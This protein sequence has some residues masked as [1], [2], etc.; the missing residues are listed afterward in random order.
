MEQGDI[1]KA[2]CNRCSGERNHFIIHVHEE[3]WSEDIGDETFVSGKD[4]Y[5]L[6]KCAGCG[7]VR[8]RHINWFEGHL[9]EE[10]QP[11][12]HI[13][14]CPPASLRRRPFWLSSVDVSHGVHV[15]L[16]SMP[17]FVSRLLREVYVALQNNCCSVAA[18][19]IRALL[20]RLMIEHV[21]DQGSF[22]GNLDAFERAG[23]VGPRQKAIIETT[24]EVGH[25][26]IHRNYNPTLQDVT[27]VLDI[28]ENIIQSIY[29]SAEQA[30]ALKSRIPPR[31]KRKKISDQ[32]DR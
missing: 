23:C 29:V 21:E 16:V 6:L 28:A 10:D 25:A 17:E 8:L 2:H 20:E 5:E 7:D 27:Q 14:Y 26:S 22:G 9:D 13:T 31:A 15:H 4:H 3:E 1:V 12:P 11:V 19:G 24:L 30:K 18:M 32:V